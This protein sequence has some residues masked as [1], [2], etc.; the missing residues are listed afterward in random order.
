MSKNIKEL[1]LDDIEIHDLASLTPS[2]TDVQYI[3]LRESIKDHGQQ[4][5]VVIYRGKV[6]DGRH[7][8]KALRELKSETIMCE[9]LNSQL[10]IEDIKEKVM[11]IYE[12]RRHQTPTQL[13]IMA[14]R[15]YISYQTIG[16]KY[17]QAEI[18]KRHGTVVKQLGRVSTLMKLAGEEIIEL[19]FNGNKLNIGT[20]ERPCLTDS[21]QSLIT[22]YKKRTEEIIKNTELS[23]SNDDFTDEEMF[24]L[25]ETVNSLIASYSGRMLNKLINVLS[26][27]INE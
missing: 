22:Y 20:L 26:N 19:L 7:R 15:D 24:E 21:L 23:R 6:I 8:V 12:N 3:A 11:N 9:I 18:C 17:G 4:V 2:M 10:S 5:P 1:K 16:E 25:R 27:S 13:A 14:Y